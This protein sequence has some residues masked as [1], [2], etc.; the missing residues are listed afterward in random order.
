MSAIR[1]RPCLRAL[2]G[3]GAFWVYKPLNERKDMKV[4]AFATEIKRKTS[5][6]RLTT[7]Y[8]LLLLRRQLSEL[9]PGTE[10][11]EKPCTPV[12]VASKGA[13]FARLI[14]KY[15][16]KTFDVVFPA[17]TFEGKASKKAAAKETEE[18]FI[19]PDEGQEYETEDIDGVGADL[20]EKLYDAGF[21]TVQSIRDAENSELVA[22]DGIGLK[23]VE[24]IKA[25]ANDME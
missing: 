2:T 9:S 4:K 12:E 17:D 14:N 10:L 5:S 22:I 24:K 21:E 18:K 25:N 8:E 3:S 20:A 19:D 16:R 7:A 13:E 11:D 15:G 1:G 6:I 23:S